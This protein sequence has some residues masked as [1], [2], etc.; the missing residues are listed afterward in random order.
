MTER[1]TQTVGRARVKGVR[2]KDCV[3]AGVGI[4]MSGGVAG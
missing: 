1:A 4:Q 3:C 2:R